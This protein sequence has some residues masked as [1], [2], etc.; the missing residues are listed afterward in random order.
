MFEVAEPMLLYKLLDVIDLRSR[1][2]NHI[3][4]RHRDRAAV[5]AQYAWTHG[6]VEVLKVVRPDLRK[7]NQIVIALD[8]A[9]RGLTF[10]HTPHRFMLIPSTDR[11][12][13]SLIDVWIVSQKIDT[14]ARD[15]PG[16]MCLGVVVAQLPGQNRG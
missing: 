4:D 8:R 14:L 13:P 1:Q 3:L 6:A 11:N 5:A 12:L 7:Q 15:R 2:T 16:D 10:E 9:A